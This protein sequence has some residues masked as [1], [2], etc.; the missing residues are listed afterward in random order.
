MEDCCGSSPFADVIDFLD[1]CLHTTYKF[2]FGRARSFV[3][4]KDDMVV[5]YCNCVWSGGGGGQGILPQKLF[6]LNGVK[7]CN[8]RQEKYGDAF[9]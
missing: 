5:L 6:V 1:N 8:Y 7:S 4:H 2:F 3:K 9:S